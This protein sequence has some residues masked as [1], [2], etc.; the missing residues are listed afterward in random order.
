MYSVL[1]M[2]VMQEENYNKG[3]EQPQGIKA[4]R[5]HRQ[6]ENKS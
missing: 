1:V 6:Y 2:R 5:F 3:T 4:L